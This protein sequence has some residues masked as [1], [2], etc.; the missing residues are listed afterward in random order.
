MPTMS[1][2]CSG[3]F[4]RPKRKNARR[5]PVSST[6]WMGHASKTTVRAKAAVR[7]PPK[8][9]TAAV[10]MRPTN[11]VAKPPRATSHAVSLRSGS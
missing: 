8:N 3:H 6:N 5:Q 2:R 1:T 11:A 9:A 7:G 10:R 4:T